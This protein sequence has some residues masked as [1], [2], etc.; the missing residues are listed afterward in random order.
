MLSTEVS[1]LLIG[2]VV[3]ILLGGPLTDWWVKRVVKRQ[4][5]P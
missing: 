3:G 5:R 1:Y 4:N 2:V